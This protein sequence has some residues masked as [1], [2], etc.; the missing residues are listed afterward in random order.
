MIFPSDKTIIIGHRGCRGLIPENTIEGFLRAVDVGVDALELDVVITGD[1][2]VLISHEPWLNNEICLDANGNEMSTAQATGINLFQLSYEQIKKFDCGLRVNPEFPEQKKMK[3]TKPLLEDMLIQLK[4]YCSQKNIPLPVVCIEIKSDEKLYGKFQPQ[5]DELVSLVVETVSKQL[6]SSQYLI[7]SFDLNILKILYEKYPE[8]K[9]SALNETV[10]N[11]EMFFDKL[12]FITL[13]YSPYYIFIDES[14]IEF[15]SRHGI[16]ILAWT[17]NNETDAAL[18]KS[19]GVRG[20]I[21]DYPDR[22]K[23]LF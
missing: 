12:G 21:T 5:P 3:A 22:I 18:L 20:I 9:L 4:E 10:E 14:A 7:Q 23:S 17:V 15:C 6:T 8:A 1:H 2:Q 11:T 19:K 13:Y 16:K